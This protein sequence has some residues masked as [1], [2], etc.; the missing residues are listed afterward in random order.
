M[1]QRAP[2]LSGTDHLVVWGRVRLERPSGARAV[3]A[4]RACVVAAQAACPSPGTCRIRRPSG[5]C[6]WSRRR[7][8]RPAPWAP[9]RPPSAREGCPWA[10]LG[11]PHSAW[12]SCMTPNQHHGG[13]GIPGT[14]PAEGGKAE[15][16][17]ADP[18]RRPAPLGTA[19]SPLSARGR[20]LHS[21]TA[22]SIQ[23]T[24]ESRTQDTTPRH[25]DPPTTKDA[26]YPDVPEDSERRRCW[27]SG[28]GS[29]A[30]PRGRQPHSPS[31]SIPTPSSVQPS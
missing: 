13:R 14:R 21:P 12:G 29:R 24:L 17:D 26:Y 5:S 9:P 28:R 27:P 8:R 18:P 25:H 11:S 15:P 22:R 1:D 30:S 6:R 7:A 10:D 3:G 16:G 2:W 23:P 31:A 4:T 20:V 19:P